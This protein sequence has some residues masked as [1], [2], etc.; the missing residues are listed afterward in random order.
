M[1]FKNVPNQCFET[2]TGQQV[3]KSRN[4]AT[5]TIV[6]RANPLDTS[7]LQVIGVKRGPKGTDIGLWCFPCGYLDY[8]ETVEEAAIREVFEE[9]N[10]LLDKG[11]LD[12]YHLD[13]NPEKKLQNVTVHFQAFYNPKEGEVEQ[14]ISS[15]NAESGEVEEVRWI[16]VEDI[17]GLE[18]AFDHKER[19]LKILT[20]VL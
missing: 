7:K 14:E 2:T 10:I 15:K 1:E 8:N 17:E 12:F 19:A 4:V 13:S 6:M 20:H 18:W 16:D 9:S 3:W 5:A 11:D